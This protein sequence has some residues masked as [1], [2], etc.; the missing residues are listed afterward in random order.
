MTLRCARC[1]G[2]DV[3]TDLE[4]V[5][6]H[7]S[8]IARAIVEVRRTYR[9]HTCGA[10]ERV[11]GGGVARSFACLGARGEPIRDDVTNAAPDRRRTRATSSTR[12]E[13]RACQ[14]CGKRFMQTGALRRSCFECWRQNTVE[15]AGSLATCVHAGAEGG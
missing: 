1:H 6:V 2:D 10:T 5:R 8:S 3:A 13:A 14:R 9:C 4:P 15:D 12:N 7:D 11:M